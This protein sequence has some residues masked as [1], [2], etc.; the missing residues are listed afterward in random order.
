MPLTLVTFAGIAFGSAWKSR[1]W[2]STQCYFLSQ[3]HERPWVA[4]K[5]RFLLKVNRY[6][7]H[8]V[9]KWHAGHSK[10]WMTP[11]KRGFDT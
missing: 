11:T 10:E 4:L 7:T 1:C 2:S 9:G 3:I 5:L 6:T 8:L